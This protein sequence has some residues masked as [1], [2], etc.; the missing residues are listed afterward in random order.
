D[1]K[2][3]DN[4]PSKQIRPST[5]NEYGSLNLQVSGYDMV[6]VEHYSQYVHNLCNRLSVKV[7]ESY[8]KP[9]KTKEVMLMQEQGTKMFVDSVL[10]THERVVQVTGLSATLAPMVLEILMMNQPEGVQLLVKEHTE[11]DYQ[12]RFK[13]RPDLENL[14]ASMN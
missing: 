1:P 14:M 13:A 3:K 10:M 11:A 8:A 2:K 4:L 6:L 12:I 7:Q 5:D 9:T